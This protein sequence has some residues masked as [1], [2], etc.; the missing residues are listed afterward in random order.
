VCFADDDD[1]LVADLVDAAAHEHM[2]LGECLVA[3]SAEI[4]LLPSTWTYQVWRDGRKN[5]LG[6]CGMVRICGLQRGQKIRVRNR[7]VAAEQANFSDIL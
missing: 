5:G 7:S 3:V 1:R 4:D 2:I 6:I